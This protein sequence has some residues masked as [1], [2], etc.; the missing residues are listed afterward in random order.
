MG[1]HE[2]IYALKSPQ[3]IVQVVQCKRL[4]GVSLCDMHAFLFV[5]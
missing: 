2:L 3:K 4:S 1:L 5:A